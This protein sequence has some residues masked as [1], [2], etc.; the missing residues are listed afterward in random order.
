MESKQLS[1]VVNELFYLSFWSGFVVFVITLVLEFH[2]SCVACATTMMRSAWSTLCSKQGQIS[3]NDRFW[4]LVLRL[5]LRLYAKNTAG[6]STLPCFHRNLQAHMLF[7]CTFSFHATNDCDDAISASAIFEETFTWIVCDELA[8]V[9]R[10]FYHPNFLFSCLCFWIREADHP[11]QRLNAT[12]V[13]SKKIQRFNAVFGSTTLWND[14]AVVRFCLIWSDF[15]N[16][17]LVKLPS[18]CLPSF[19]FKFIFAWQL[20]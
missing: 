1:V 17:R 8:C 16:V 10:V 6:T 3:R 20:F 13:I 11:Q 9:F 4:A 14:P 2:P 5:W 7:S 12:C 18:A 19:V 15:V